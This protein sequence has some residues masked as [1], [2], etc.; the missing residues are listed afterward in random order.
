MVSKVYSINSLL[1]SFVS[2]LLPQQPLPMRRFS[3]LLAKAAPAKRGPVQPS[4]ADFLD[5]LL[6]SKDELL[7]STVASNDKILAF[8]EKLLASNDKLLAVKDEMI[9]QLQ[10]Q[11]Q[12][13]K[14][15]LSRRSLFE[16]SM[17]VVWRDLWKAEHPGKPVPQKIN[18]TEAGV[19]LSKHAATLAPSGDPMSLHEHIMLCAKNHS[20]GPIYASLS[21]DIHGCGIS[22]S[23]MSEPSSKLTDGQNKFLQCLLKCF[24]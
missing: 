22:A 2:T 6:A 7:A 15:I 18:M 9:A 5:K 20:P 14:G 3:L 13:A 8:N 21:E 23:S 11:V 24:Y 1:F 12:V 4:S 17:A 16:I 19:L 10:V